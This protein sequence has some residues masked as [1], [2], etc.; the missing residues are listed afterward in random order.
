MIAQA[1]EACQSVCEVIT[2]Q[3]GHIRNCLDGHNAQMFCK[4]LGFLFFQVISLLHVFVRSVLTRLQVLFSHLKKFSVSVG[5]GG[6]Q[7]LLD[8]SLYSQ[9]ARGFSV[10]ALDSQFANLKQL[11]NIH[12][13]EEQSIRPL[14][15]DLVGQ[16][17]PLQDI[18]HYLETHENFSNSWLSWNIFL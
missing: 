4:S 11:C 17:M 14:L 12:L 18:R 5:A 2:Q 1:S 10:S 15:K 3:L 7:V 16:G 9:T 6:S 13:V 8:L